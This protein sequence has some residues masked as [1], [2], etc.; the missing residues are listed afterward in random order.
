[1]EVYF[2]FTSASTQKLA[3]MLQTGP[4]LRF[5]ISAGNHTQSVSGG[6][7]L[8]VFSDHCAE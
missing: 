5:R 3:N 4:P 7:F 1:M 2:E 8:A 6:S